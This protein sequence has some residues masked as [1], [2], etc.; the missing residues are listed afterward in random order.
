MKVVHSRA[1]VTGSLGS[2]VLSGS[3]LFLQSGSFWLVYPID[4]GAPWLTDRA[5]TGMIPL[6]SELVG[7][8][9]PAGFSL[10]KEGEDLLLRSDALSEPW[11]MPPGEV[12]FLS[13][14]AQ[15]VLGSNGVLFTRDNGNLRFEQI[16]RL[17]LLACLVPGGQKGCGCEGRG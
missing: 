6:T 5:P 15:P 14:L 12:R 2:P 1:F 11:V 9:P 16:Q 10:S 7:S 13:A 4:G 17:F 8:G 3:H